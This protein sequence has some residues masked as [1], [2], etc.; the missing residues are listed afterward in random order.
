MIGRWL[1]GRHPLD[2]SYGAWMSKPGVEVRATTDPN[3]ML[4]SP[5]KKNEQILLSG[6]VGVGAGG[7]AT[8]F[9]PENYSSIPFVQTFVSNQG[10]AIIYPPAFYS[11]DGNSVIYVQ[12]YTNAAIFQ[13][14]SNLTLVF[15]YTVCARSD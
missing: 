13:N 11:P 2:G 7:D 9:Y 8:I 4:I 12:Q 3:N 10:G 15:F 14:R 5:L 6:L 1:H